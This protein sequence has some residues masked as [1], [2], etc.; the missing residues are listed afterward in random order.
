MIAQSV[1]TISLPEKRNPESSVPTCIALLWRRRQG[2]GS[3]MISKDLF[4]LNSI[5]DSKKPDKS[6]HLESVLTHLQYLFNYAP[7]TLLIEGAQDTQAT[8]NAVL[9]I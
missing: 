5:A 9:R 1:F 6:L 4:L 2:Q 8:C 3:R 7:F